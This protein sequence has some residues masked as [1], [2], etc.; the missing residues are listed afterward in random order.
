MLKIC[1]SSIYGLLELIF[2]KAL[3][4]GLFPSNWKKKDPIHKNG[5]KQF[6]RN[7]RSVSLLQIRGKI[8]KK[9]IFD[10]LFK[11]LPEN[12]LTSPN[13]FQFKPEGSCVNQLLY[14]T[15]EVYNSF[16]EGLEVRSVFLD[17]S[18]TFD[19]LWNKGL[20]FNCRKMV[21]LVT[22]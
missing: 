22:S 4:T 11:F 17:I 13:Q 5:D 3:S 9:L 15:H 20:L 18:K 8:F 2:K 19:K 16:G 6:L 7:Y 12:N 1:D 14:K 21:Y 10:K